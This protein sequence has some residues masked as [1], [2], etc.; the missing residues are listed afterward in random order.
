MI[1]APAWLERPPKFR[2]KIMESALDERLDPQLSFE[3]AH[4]EK[5]YDVTILSTVVGVAIGAII[6]IYALAVSVTVTPNEFGM[7]VAFP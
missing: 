4:P 5:S 2:R 6:A 7:M 1:R 3:R